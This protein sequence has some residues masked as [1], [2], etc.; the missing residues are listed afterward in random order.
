[1]SDD[2]RSLSAQL[3]AEP[4]SMAFLPLGEALRRRG[5][6]AAALAVAETGARRYPALADAWDLIAR[7][8]SD[9]GEG[10]AAFDAWTEALRFDPRHLGALRGL[11]YLAFR[12]GDVERAERHLRAAAEAL[13][14]DA[15]VQRALERVGTARRQQPAPG[16]DAPPGG[17]GVATLLMDDQGRLLAGHLTRPQGGDVSE[18]VAAQLA[19]VSREASRATRLLDLG[20]WM[21]LAVEC[22]DR[23][24]YLIPPT[25]DS[26]LLASAPAEL[27]AG[28][29]ALAAERA[30]AAARRWLER[31]A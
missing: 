16:G 26:L 3:A 23:G 30:G 21:G 22:P 28:R 9:R 17:E 14:D 31:L 11:A 24:L 13:P 19:G 6:F 5:Q 1:M 10:D 4:H 8:R 20:D 27:P 2:I 18:A 7:I 15:G 12:A 25:G 29:L